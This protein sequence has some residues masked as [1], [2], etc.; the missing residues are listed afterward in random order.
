MHFS[1]RTFGLLPSC[2]RNIPKDDP[3]GYGKCMSWG[4]RWKIISRKGTDVGCVVAAE[5]SL[6]NHLLIQEQNSVLDP[7]STLFVR[8][9]PTTVK[10][11]SGMSSRL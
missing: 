1:Y 2:V 4:L 9:N 10:R 3:Y 7:R 11:N 6:P 8:I 5:T